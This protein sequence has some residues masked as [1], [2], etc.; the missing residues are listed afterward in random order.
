MFRDRSKKIATLLAIVFFGLGL[1]LA[2]RYELNPLMDKIIIVAGLFFLLI[3]IFCFYKSK[4]I[5][6]L[7]LTGLLLM[8]GSYGIFFFFG[9]SHIKIVY[10]VFLIV[11]FIALVVY[12]IGLFKM[13]KEFFND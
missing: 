8:L 5:F 9:E 13:T 11:F 3:S 6:L 1:L 2:N 7:I 10:I 12:N 4:R